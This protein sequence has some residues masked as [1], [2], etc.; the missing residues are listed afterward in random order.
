MDVLY[1][2]FSHGKQAVQFLSNL[3]WLLD[4]NPTHEQYQARLDAFTDFCE[5]VTELFDKLTE[6]E[7]RDLLYDAYNYLWGIKVRVLFHFVPY[8]SIRNYTTLEMFCN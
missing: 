1:L 2:P 6:I 3:N 5:R 4:N 8:N 7:N